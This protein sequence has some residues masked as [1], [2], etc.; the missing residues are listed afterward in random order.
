MMRPLQIFSP[1]HPFW[2]AG[3]RPFFAVAILM[4]FFMPTIWGLVFSGKLALPQ[5]MNPIQWHA[6]EMFYGFAGAVLIGFL[7][8][9]SKNWVKV[10]GIHGVTLMVLVGLWIIERVFIYSALTSEP[11]FKHI[12]LS[13]FFAGS[14]F[15]IIN[16]LVRNREKDS[17]PDNYFFVIL[18]VFI[19]VAK[20]LLVSTSHYQDGVAMTVG[21]FRLAFV[22]MFER[23]IPQFM[24][25]TEGQALF[26]N[27]ILDTSIKVLVLLSAFEGFLPRMLGG[28]LLILTGSLLLFRW[29]VWRPDIGFRKFGN[30]TMYAG[31]LGLVLHFIFAGLQQAGIWS[32]GTIALHIFTLFCL[33]VVIP[34]M[35]VRISQG[36]TGRKPQFLVSDK[37]AIVLFFLSGISR[38]VFPVIFP[39]DYSTWIM[40]AGLLWSIAF[41]ILGVRLM[42]FLF[43][44]RIDGKEH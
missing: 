27:K 13:L 21:L 30:A 36:H 25:N 23:T 42:P 15:Y 34:S 40:V 32:S 44:A 11:L 43:Q 31:Y 6:H 9:S 41:L 2:L 4:G 22:V 10:R 38:V 37:I 3:F 8:T 39:A 12:G 33:G 35:I 7:L 29:I 19:L 17:F 16:T 28:S 24:K 14:G 5:G 1:R 20:N 26:R 18:L